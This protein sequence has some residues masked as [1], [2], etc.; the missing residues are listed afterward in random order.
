[1]VDR[2]A[3]VTRAFYTSGYESV[4]GSVWGA[5]PCSDHLASPLSD[6]ELVGVHTKDE[7]PSSFLCV[8]NIYN[9]FIFI[10]RRFYPG[11]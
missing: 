6:S 1:V 8:Y 5:T 4:N 3:A 9:R 2:A 11:G 10:L 7:S